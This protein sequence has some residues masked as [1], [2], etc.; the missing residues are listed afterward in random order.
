[1]NAWVNKFQILFFFIFMVVCPPPAS[2]TSVLDQPVMDDNLIRCKLNVS[3]LQFQDNK[4]DLLGSIMSK[5]EKPPTTSTQ[6][7]RDAKKKQMEEVKKMKE[8]EKDMLLEFRKKVGEWFISFWG[9]FF[10]NHLLFQ[11]YNSHRY[12][13]E[14]K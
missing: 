9:N 14:E 1:M 5:M 4:M 12:Q 3:N 11:L 6:A 8:R 2:K 13:G 10:S 7:Q